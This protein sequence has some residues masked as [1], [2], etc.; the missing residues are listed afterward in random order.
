M[1]LSGEVDGCWCPRGAGIRRAFN[2]LTVDD[3]PA[4]RSIRRNDLIRRRTL[5]VPAS[6]A[7]PNSRRPLSL[8]SASAR[9]AAAAAGVEPLAQSP[10]EQGRR[11]GYLS[12]GGSCSRCPSRC[13]SANSRLALRSV[14]CRASLLDGLCEFGFLFQRSNLRWQLAGEAA[15]AGPIPLLV[16]AGRSRASFVARER[17]GLLCSGS[18]C[19][20]VVRKS[21]PDRGRGRGGGKWHGPAEMPSPP[22]RFARLAPRGVV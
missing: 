2:L 17:V 22:E 8:L 15:A 3:P 4:R 9:S 7:R 14:R 10:V 1:S 21:H 12:L 20:A 16:T 13:R 19:S 18:S 11:C 6:G 5:D